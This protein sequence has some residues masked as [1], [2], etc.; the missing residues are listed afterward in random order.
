MHAKRDAHWRARASHRIDGD[1]ARCGRTKRTRTSRCPVA[2]VFELRRRECPPPLQAAELPGPAEVRPTRVRGRRNRALAA[3][4]SGF[5]CSVNR[6]DSNSCEPN[7]PERELARS[8]DTSSFG[9]RPPLQR[10]TSRLARTRWRRPPRT[11]DAEP[12]VRL[13]AF[14][15]SSRPGLALS[16][17]PGSHHSCWRILLRCGRFA[18]AVRRPPIPWRRCSS[19]E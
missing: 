12:H 1:E 15:P 13:R 4:E 8:R 11:Q 19:A 7:H 6:Q 16:N 2:L 5:G 17:P 9:P 10:D 18:I 14:P 3:P